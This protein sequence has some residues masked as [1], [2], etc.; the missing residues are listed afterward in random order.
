MSNLY[1]QRNISG[2]HDDQT[3]HVSFQG[4]DRAVSQLLSIFASR[5]SF[6]KYKTSEHLC[7]PTSQPVLCL[8]SQ[9]YSISLHPEH[10]LKLQIS[11]AICSQGNRFGLC[12]TVARLQLHTGMSIT[13]TFGN[14]GWEG[15]VGWGTFW[16]MP[17]EHMSCTT[18][19]VRHP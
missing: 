2:N 12:V 6:V 4:L 1:N 13:T 19:T 8:R 17:R 5:V 18:D 10:L 11:T 7:K 16:G 15:H 3:R 9:V 14:W